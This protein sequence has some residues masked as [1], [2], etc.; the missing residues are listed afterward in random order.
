VQLTRVLREAVSN[1]I[2]HSVGCRT[3]IRI[4]SRGDQFV[5]EVEDDGRGLAQT[6]GATGNGLGNIE[7]RVRSIGGVHAWGRGELGGTRLLVSL[8]LA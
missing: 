1:T 3:R 6:A 7:R 4:D 2:R 5:M 8:R